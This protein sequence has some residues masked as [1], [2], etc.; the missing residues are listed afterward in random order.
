MKECESYW[1]RQEA[2]NIKKK[3][4]ERIYLTSVSPDMTCIDMKVS[5]EKRNGG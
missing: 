2:T 1:V 3:Y 4:T 5:T